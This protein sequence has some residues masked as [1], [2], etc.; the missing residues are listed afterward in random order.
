M[1][2]TFAK[3]CLGDGP[4]LT[5]YFIAE[6]L[7][8]FSFLRDAVGF[9]N[10]GFQVSDFVLLTASELHRGGCLGDDHNGFSPVPVGVGESCV[11]FPLVE[12]HFGILQVAAGA[13][14]GYELL[15]DFFC[16]DVGNDIIDADFPIYFLCL[17]MDLLAYHFRDFTKMMGNAPHHFQVNQ[18]SSSQSFGSNG[19]CCFLRFMRCCILCWRDSSNSSA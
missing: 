15:H 4:H 10:V 5:I 16:V 3:Q 6:V 2:A 17:D 18:S 13:T 7:Y 11:E 12:V 9:C 19:S 8:F 14:Q 1:A